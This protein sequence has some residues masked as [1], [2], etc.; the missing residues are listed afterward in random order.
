MTRRRRPET[1]PA[2]QPNSEQ[3]SQHE[4]ALDLLHEALDSRR[5]DSDRT[6]HMLN[7]AEDGGEIKGANIWREGRS[8]GKP[9]LA[10]QNVRPECSPAMRD[11]ARLRLVSLIA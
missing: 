4:Q 3:V 10:G 5:M 6:D 1:G 9:S 2:A 11:L 8:Q 7:G